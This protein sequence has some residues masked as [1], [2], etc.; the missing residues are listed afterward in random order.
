[1]TATTKQVL[2]ISWM[3]L[4]GLGIVVDLFYRCNL[5]ELCVL[6]GLTVIGVLTFQAAF[7]LFDPDVIEASSKENIKYVCEQQTKKWEDLQ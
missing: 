6:T 5:E 4:F 2:A 7:V 3:L 1:M